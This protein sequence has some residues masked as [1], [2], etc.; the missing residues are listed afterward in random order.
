MK[1][2]RGLDG[3]TADEDER[4][5]SEVGAAV[6]QPFWD[7]V[8]SALMRHLDAVSIE[9]LC[10]RADPARIVWGSDFGFGWSDPIEY[11]LALMRRAAIDG[12]VRDAILGT[13]PRRLL[14]GGRGAGKGDA[15]AVEGQT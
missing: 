4:A 11:R 5:S 8:E 3:Q 10:R 13:N 1:V 14:E 7:E 6:V 2:V 12:P 15:M 9:E